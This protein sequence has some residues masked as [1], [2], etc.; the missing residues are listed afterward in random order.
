MGG[1]RRSR[2]GSLVTPRTGAA[3]SSENPSR[4]TSQNNPSET[5]WKIAEV[6]STVPL[7]WQQAGTR[8]PLDPSWPPSEPLFRDPS[9]FSK[10]FLRDC[11]EIRNGSP[12]GAAKAAKMG[13][14][15]PYRPPLTAKQVRSRRLQLFSKQSRK[16]NSQKFGS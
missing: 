9:R 3:Q 2:T 12:I 11:L 8:P 1:L 13:R 16:W 4:R 5:V 15:S 7:R 10:Q 14:R 6:I